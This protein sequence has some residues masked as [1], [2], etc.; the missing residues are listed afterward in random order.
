MKINI[1]P[2]MLNLDIEIVVD[3]EEI[4]FQDFL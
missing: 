4:K 1:T 2:D 3:A